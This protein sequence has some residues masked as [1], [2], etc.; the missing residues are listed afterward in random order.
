[1]H[2]PLHNT[3]TSPDPKAPPYWQL[4]RDESIPNPVPGCPDIVPLDI[5]TVPNL[6]REFN[7]LATEE[8]LEAAGRFLAQQSTT[9]SAMHSDGKTGTNLTYYTLLATYCHMT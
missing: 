4:D 2:N 3:H 1:M 6:S 7:L 8:G 9:H 5:S